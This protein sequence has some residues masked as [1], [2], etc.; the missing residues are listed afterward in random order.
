MAKQ[1]RRPARPTGQV[2]RNKAAPAQRFPAP[3]PPKK[4]AKVA[5][6]APASVPDEPRTFRLGVVPG[7]TPGKWIDA[8]KQR[9]PHV[10][11]E[12]VPITVAA[13]L[14]AL[15]EVD[16]ALVR[17]PLDD[18]SLHVIPLYDELPVVVASIESH[19][20]AADELTLADLAG[21]VVMTPS[22]DALVPFKVP[23]STPPAFSPLATD[24]AIATAATGIGVVIVPMSLARL[25]HRKDADHRVL[26]DGPTST[27]ALAWPR[28]RTT[29]DVETFVGIVRGRTANSSR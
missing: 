18:D 3:K 25:H 9:M 12:L 4:T 10:P 26:A 7:A 29:P 13:Q 28:K 24:E 11:I 22:D 27:V 1:Q 8:W 6:D 2:R 14:E 21:E 17:L 23:G 19:L 15:R 16:A 20:L 5:F